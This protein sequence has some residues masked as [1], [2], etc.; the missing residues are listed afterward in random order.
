VVSWKDCYTGPFRL[1]A[2]ESQWV[3]IGLNPNCE[4]GWSRKFDVLRAPAAWLA[5]GLGH[6]DVDLIHDPDRAWWY[7]WFSGL[8]TNWQ[9]SGDITFNFRYRC[10]QMG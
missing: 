1:G 10:F 9:F 2:W 7:S 5:V 3:G 4:A 8:V 6:Q